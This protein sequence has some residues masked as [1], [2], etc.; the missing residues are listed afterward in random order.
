MKITLTAVINICSCLGVVCILP[1][2]TYPYEVSFHHFNSIK[3]NSKVE[4]ILIY[5][6]PALFE[7]PTY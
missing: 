5:I 7:I 4:I 1:F 3:T 2:F 6:K